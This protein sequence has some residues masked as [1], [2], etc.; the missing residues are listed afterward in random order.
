[1]TELDERPASADGDDD[2]D[3]GAVVEVDRN[4]LLI[5]GRA[6]CLRL[7]GSAM[8]GRIGITF[9]A[10]PV[11]LPINFHLVDERILFRTGRGTK[12]DAATYNAVVAFEVDDMDPLSHTGWSV[13]VTGLA[14]EVTDPVALAEL[15]IARIPYWAPVE[16]DRV[17]EISTEMISGRRIVPGVH[18]DPR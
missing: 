6:E 10:L 16:G 11:I 2:D 3:E 1:M 15:E 13:M 5:L 12:L 9:G 4:G 8:L 7:L 17:V 18:V 14:S